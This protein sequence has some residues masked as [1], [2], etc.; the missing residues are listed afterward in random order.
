MR[1]KIS[2]LKQNIG[3]PDIRPVAL[4]IACGK[5]LFLNIA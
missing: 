5:E 3:G 4:V 1:S 2:I